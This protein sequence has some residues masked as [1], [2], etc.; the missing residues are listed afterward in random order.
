MCPGR[1]VE[2][3]RR[4]TSART[5]VPW[6]GVGVEGLPADV[7]PPP[8]GWDRDTPLAASRWAGRTAVDDFRVVSP[9]SAFVRRRFQVS[10]RAS[11]AR[12]TG[13]QSASWS[14]HSAANAVGSAT[15][16]AARENGP[17]SAASRGEPVT[18]VGAGPSVPSW[19]ARAWRGARS[20][21]P[22][23]APTNDRPRGLAAIIAWARHD[24]GRTADSSAAGTRRRRVRRQPPFD[25]LCGSAVR[26]ITLAT[27]AAGRRRTRTVLPPGSTGR[28]LAARLT[29]ELRSV[30]RSRPRGL[31]PPPAIARR[32][33]HRETP[34]HRAPRCRRQQ[35]ST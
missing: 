4:E 3:G 18:H 24:D 31:A 32:G 34:A 30:P 29:D 9:Q 19:P 6:S 20:E 33:F 15:H 7:F 11:P 21:M 12:S 5:D 1:V 13:S 28:R 10:R 22:E 8:R 2:L 27:P 16:G 14:A 17:E 35:R 25:A 26:P 23:Q